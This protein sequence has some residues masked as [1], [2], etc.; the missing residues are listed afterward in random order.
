[1]NE[2]TVTLPYSN[3]ESLLNWKA[4]AAKKHDIFP[5]K[6]WKKDLNKPKTLLCHDMKGG[7][8]EDKYI[9]FFGA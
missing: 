4:D 2:P 8:L 1:M 3:F 9:Y 6:E 7:Y 5:Y